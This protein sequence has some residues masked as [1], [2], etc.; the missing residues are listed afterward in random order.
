MKT[1]AAACIHNTQYIL[2]RPIVLRLPNTVDISSGVSP[3][4]S[5]IIV[6]KIFP[7]SIE[8]GSVDDDDVVSDIFYDRL[9]EINI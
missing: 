4:P 2:L 6:F 8:I 9:Y 5:L 3:F 1:N 7:F